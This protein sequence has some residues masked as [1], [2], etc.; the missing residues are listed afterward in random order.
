MDKR[1]NIKISVTKEMVAAGF[2]VLSES[3]ISE[4]YLGADRLTVAEIYR[5]MYALRPRR[6]SRRPVDR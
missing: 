6:A 2:R 3:G 1:D 4:S 5:A